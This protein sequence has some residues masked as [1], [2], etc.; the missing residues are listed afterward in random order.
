MS[1]EKTYEFEIPK[2][3][4]DVVVSSLEDSDVPIYLQEEIKER[5][6]GFGN[7]DKRKKPSHTYSEREFK[8]LGINL[9]GRVMRHSVKFKRENPDKFLDDFKKDNELYKLACKITYRVAGAT[10]ADKF[11]RDLRDRCD[12]SVVFDEILRCQVRLFR[13]GSKTPTYNCMSY[14]E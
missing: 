3:M 6:F 8:V 13:D 11:E 12:Y 14:S 9:R 5:F 1:S 10:G 2:E 7:G 4:N